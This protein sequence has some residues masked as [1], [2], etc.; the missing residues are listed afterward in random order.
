MLP[1]ISKTPDYL[2]A[3]DRVYRSPVTYS[4]SQVPVITD[5]GNDGLP[6]AIHHEIDSRSNV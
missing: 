4:A 6:P 1:S 3:F 2:I 5:R